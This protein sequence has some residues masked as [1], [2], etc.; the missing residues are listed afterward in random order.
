MDVEVNKTKLDEASTRRG[1]TSFLYEA[2]VNTEH[3]K[4]KEHVLKSELNKLFPNMGLA[5]VASDTG[6]DKIWKMPSWVSVIISSGIY[7]IQL[8]SH[9]RYQFCPKTADCKSRPTAELS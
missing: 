2:R 7:R 8:Q 6:R 5:Q 3:D 9:S 1:V 4:D